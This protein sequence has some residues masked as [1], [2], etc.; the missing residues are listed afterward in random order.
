M[1][2]TI[3]KVIL[4]E[5]CETDYS[6]EEWE[7]LVKEKIFNTP[8]KE[9]I[10]V[11]L[12]QQFPVYNENGEIIGIDTTSPA[13]LRLYRLEV[14]SSGDEFTFEEEVKKQGFK[15]RTLELTKQNMSYS[16]NPYETNRKILSNE[17]IKK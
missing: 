6:K 8:L 16:F 11:E 2:N 3:K 4:K 7:A 1:R 15:C 13:I 9:K 5:Y 17:T 10:A 12:L 14:D